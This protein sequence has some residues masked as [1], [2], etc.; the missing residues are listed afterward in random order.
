MSRT[1]CQRVNM[2]FLVP[3]RKHVK[4]Q[5]YTPDIPHVL[6]SITNPYNGQQASACCPASLF[7]SENRI[8]AQSDAEDQ[9]PEWLKAVPVSKPGTRQ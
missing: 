6:V 4:K 5:Q 7:P 2:G 1:V 3:G 9:I 8:E